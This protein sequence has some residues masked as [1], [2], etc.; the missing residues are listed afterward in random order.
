VG[1]NGDSVAQSDSF[2]IGPLLPPTTWGAGEFKPGYQALAI[3]V[4]IKPG[5]YQLTLSLYDPSTMENA[6]YSKSGSPSSTE[7]FLLANVQIDDTI[8]L[9]HADA[10]GQ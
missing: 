10:V 6:A 8:E 7:P 5:Q 2:P 1:A 4:D 3:P 9:D